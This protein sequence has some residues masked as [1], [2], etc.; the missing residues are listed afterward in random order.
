L[1]A[2]TGNQGNSRNNRARLNQPR[3]REAKIH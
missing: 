3:A 2:A 1:I